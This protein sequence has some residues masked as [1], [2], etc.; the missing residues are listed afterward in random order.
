[1]LR[2]DGPSLYF[3]GASGYGPHFAAAGASQRPDVAVVPIGGYLPRALR[4]DHMS[5]QDALYAFDDLRARLMVPIRYA[6]FQLSY[7]RLEDPLRWLAELVRERG[8]DEN[9]AALP[10][11]A[12]RKFSSAAAIPAAPPA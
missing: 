8:L 4:A 6:T 7:E 2:G 10:P 9:V 5:P 11:G 1:M 3:C 12:S